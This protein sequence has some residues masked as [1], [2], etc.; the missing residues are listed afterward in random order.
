MRGWHVRGWHVRGGH[1]MLACKRL[2]CKRLICKRL[3]CKVPPTNR[4]H[5]NQ[6]EADEPTNVDGHL[7]ELGGGCCSRVLGVS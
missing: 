2:V 4:G 1:T 7:W 6:P 3:E 5:R